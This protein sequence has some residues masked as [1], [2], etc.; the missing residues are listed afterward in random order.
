MAEARVNL[1]EGLFLLNQQSASA[2]FA[3]TVDFVRQ[4]FQRAEAELIVLRK[5]DER[6]LAYEV[7]GQKRGVYL[8]AYFRARGTQIANIERDCNLS[9]QIL[10]A[11]ILKADH[12]GELELEAAKQG[13]ELSLE[14]KLR[15]PGPDDRGGD[16]GPAG[17]T[18]A[19]KDDVTEAPEEGAR[20]PKADTDR[21]V[22]VPDT[23]K[24]EE[25]SRDAESTAR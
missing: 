19:R 7:K 20:K 14:A 12:M 1:Y 11:L 13:A 10:R 17:A 2:D 24:D 8:L 5:W 6:T 21:N 23:A 4:V 16:R 15:S 3:G 9:E 25:G 22:T 18:A